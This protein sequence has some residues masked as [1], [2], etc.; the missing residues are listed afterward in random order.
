MRD[1]ERI[2]FANAL[3][4]DPD[5]TS[6]RYQTGKLALAGDFRSMT[7]NQKRWWK[8]AV[9]MDNRSVP[10]Y[11]GTVPGP[12]SNKH[13]RQ[14]GR[15]AN[16]WAE[17]ADVDKIVRDA[18]ASMARDLDRLANTERD[19]TYVFESPKYPGLLKI[20]SAAVLKTRVRSQLDP[21]EEY[22]T[23]L[24]VYKALRLPHEV[25]ERQR[26]HTQFDALR[27][28]Q[29]NRTECF[30]VSNV[31]ELD[32]ATKKWDDVVYIHPMNLVISR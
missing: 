10:V 9:L 28:P 22:V 3:M 23:V 21:D 11:D 12:S 2:S 25:V 31:A 8:T 17:S 26:F 13:H 7:G 15:I 5:P 30:S 20:G 27:V 24:R 18:A 32:K 29:P 16:E 1:K 4:L 19:V 6:D 14:A